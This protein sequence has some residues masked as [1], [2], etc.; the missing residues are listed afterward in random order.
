MNLLDLFIKI[1]AQ[2]EASDKI[3]GIS[4]KVG[5]GLKKA[6]AIG[7][8]A[9][10]AA[11]SAVGALGKQAVESYADYEQ[12]VGGVETLFGAGGQ[13]LSEFVSNSGKSIDEAILEYK[14]LESSQ[15][16]VLA[17]AGN[18]WKT[19]GMSANEYME[20]V[21][22]FSASLLQSLDGDTAKA[23]SVADMAITDMSDNANKMGT[24]M[25]SIQ[26]A[27]QGFAKQNYTMLDN[28]K[29]GY[30]GTKEEMERLLEDA[31]K[32]S[33]QEYD[34]SNLND[35][36][37]AIHVVQTEMGITGT[38]AKEASSTIS[39]SVS[40]MKAAW[41][42]LVTGLADDNADFEQLTSDFVESVTTAGENIIPRIETTLQGVSSLVSSASSTLIPL[43][44]ATLMANL[45]QLI[46][47]GVELVIALVT[48]LL[49]ALPQL[50]EAIPEIVK[51][52][53]EALKEAWPQ[54]QEAGQ[55]VVDALKDGILAAW[56]SFKQ[57]VSG[58]WEGIKSI[59][60]INRSDVKVV[61]SGGAGHAGGLD[62]VP[63]NGYMTQLH[64]GEM[65][66]TA[67]EA[68][69]YRNGTNGGYAGNIVENF[70]ADITLDLDGATLARKQYK[71]NMNQQTYHG[72]ALIKA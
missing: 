28:L 24:S 50:I 15:N 6:A 4:E 49:Q 38:T 13:S 44:I 23:A 64:R 37:E 19:A 54:I 63:Y 56:D 25:E 55:G 68:S 22:S 47:S 70:V 9:V 69:N 5:N 42:N 20:T 29:L 33:G 27:Y 3:S 61:G 57:F 16:T 52:V 32:F 34:I 40:S 45:P 72:S 67:R 65:V 62:Y 66:L 11:A 43:V 14:R 12:L 35:V 53:V 21:T 18:A 39:G 31:E 46:V 59:F 7:A 48:G 71:Y 17:N 36:Y 26:N 30:G 10:G 8:A 58:L 1:T 51:A 60:T 41:S 2:D